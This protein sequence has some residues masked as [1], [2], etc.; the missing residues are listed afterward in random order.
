[1]IVVH[2][3][4]GA[5]SLQRWLVEQGYPTDRLASSSGY[6]ILHH[7]DCERLVH[8]SASAGTRFSATHRAG[9]TSIRNRE[10]FGRGV[11]EIAAPS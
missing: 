9:S 7:T 11:A 5:D 10:P 1:M 2:K 6:R 8:G 3:H 4:L